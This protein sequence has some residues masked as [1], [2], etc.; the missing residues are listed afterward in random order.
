MP[1]SR[2]FDDAISKLKSERRY[3][4]FADIERD[5][6]AF[7]SALWHGPE[8]VEEV[9]IWCSNDYLG[10]GRHPQVI[11]AMT[12]AAAR[13]GAGAGGTRNISGTN[14]PLV[15]LEAELASLH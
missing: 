1:Y 2:F 13:H 11:D 14:H 9:V 8:R 7:P 4:V 15:E 3:R 6:Q 12:L 5:A 10:M